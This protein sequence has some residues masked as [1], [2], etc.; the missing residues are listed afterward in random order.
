M[1]NIFLELVVMVFFG[2]VFGAI[3]AFTLL[4]EFK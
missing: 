2:V 3:F 1:K 4:E